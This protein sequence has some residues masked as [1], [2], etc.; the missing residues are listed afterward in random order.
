MFTLQ[1]CNF[2][3]SNK[4]LG[5]GYFYR[6][7]GGEIKDI[8]C[9]S[10]NRG[11]VPSTVVSYDFD[12]KFIIVKQKPKL[13]QDPLYNKDYEYDK[14]DYEFYY[15]LIVK[16]EDLVLGPLNFDEFIKQKDKYNVSDKLVFK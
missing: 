2:S 10:T 11:E 6:N 8:L 14:G 16:K 4:S 13:P 1:S 12:D 7:E 3:D 15:L 9:K 5:N